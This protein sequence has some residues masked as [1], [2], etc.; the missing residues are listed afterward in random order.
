MTTTPVDLLREHDDD[1]GGESSAEGKEEGACVGAMATAPGQCAM[2]ATDGLPAPSRPS[3]ATIDLA[4]RGSTSLVRSSHV[5]DGPRQS[6][7]TQAADGGPPCHAAPVCCTRNPHSRRAAEAP[8]GADATATRWQA[9][10][11]VHPSK[12]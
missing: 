12:I 11:R 3:T 1:S 5:T 9:G 2:M 8:T 4:A 7:P 10:S 6:P